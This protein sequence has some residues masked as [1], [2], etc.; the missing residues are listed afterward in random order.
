[1]I[2]NEQT[3][4]VDHLSGECA[5]AGQGIDLVDQDGEPCG[6]VV[7]I[8]RVNSAGFC[9]FAAERIQNNGQM[10]LVPERTFCAWAYMVFDE[11]PVEFVR[12]VIIAG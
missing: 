11:P 1:M 10:L 3:V 5:D 12:S 6:E 8:E 4:L 9:C 7:D 2:F